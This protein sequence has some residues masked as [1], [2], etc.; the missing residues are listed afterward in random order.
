MV[1][2]IVDAGDM[3]GWWFI[4]NVYI[5]MEDYAGA[6]DCYE[7]AANG[8]GNCQYLAAYDLA[9]LYRDGDGRE[10]NNGIALELYHRAAE[11]GVAAAMRDL[12]NMF[13]NGECV[14]KDI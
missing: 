9:K 7:K 8:E 14:A 1:S 5:E 2:K 3:D 12:G 13:S 4:G 6:A 11:H 10:Q